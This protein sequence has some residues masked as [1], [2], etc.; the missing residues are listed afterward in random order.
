MNSKTCSKCGEEKLSE[1][2]HWKRTEN[3][4]NSW[5]KKCV[6]ARQRRRWID[7]KIKAAKLFGGKCVKCGY[8]RNL[9][10]L[11]FHHLDPTTKKYQWTKLRERPWEEVVDELKKC[12][13]VCRNC[14]A[15]LHNPQLDK[16]VLQYENV[17]NALLVL[18][19]NE[20]VPTGQCFAC[21]ADVYGTLYCSTKCRAMN[22]R[23]VKRP[24]KGSLA[25]K[26]LKMS[27]CA[28]GREFG[29]SDNAVRKW[30]KGYDLLV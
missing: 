9:A 10:A 15:E 21:K 12:T 26:L 23:K 29:V 22:Q 2:F 6:Y 14:H 17:D 25:R 7:R 1:E 24:S 13:L 11:D 19:K 27:W 20:I 16:N 5:C 4:P 8:D 30:A 3:R 18:E 28:I